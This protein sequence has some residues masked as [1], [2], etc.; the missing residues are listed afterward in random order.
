MECRIL[1]SYKQS[2]LCDMP[3]LDDATI[4]MPNP[5]MNA[6]Q[7]QVYVCFCKHNMQRFS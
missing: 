5:T 6:P 2:E 7:Q 4:P 3:L 1:S